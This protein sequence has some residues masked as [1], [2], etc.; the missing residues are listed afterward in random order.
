[1]KQYLRTPK[2]PVNILAQTKDQLLVLYDREGHDE[3]TWAG[4]MQ[5]ETTKEYIGLI[6]I[7][8]FL[9]GKRNYQQIKT[10]NDKRRE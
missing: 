8:D 9:Q 7:N 1:M 4:T 5:Y 10:L 6:S 2:E 3:K